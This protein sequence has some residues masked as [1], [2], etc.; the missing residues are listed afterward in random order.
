MSGARTGSLSPG[1]HAWTG[2]LLTLSR[3]DGGLA[4]LELMPSPFLMSPAF[5][6]EK[7]LYT[8]PPFHSHRGL[9][10]FFLPSRR[11]DPFLP[12]AKA[13]GRGIGAVQMASGHTEDS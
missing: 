5:D 7:W 8:H 10:R 3:P 12:A 11:A 9:F 1:S 4:F 2:P 13:L 6:P